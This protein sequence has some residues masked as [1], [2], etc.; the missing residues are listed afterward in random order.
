MTCTN[1]R[2]ALIDRGTLSLVQSLFGCTEADDGTMKN[3]SH[4]RETE[5]GRYFSH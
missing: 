2:L 5:I 4:Q 3:G 1:E